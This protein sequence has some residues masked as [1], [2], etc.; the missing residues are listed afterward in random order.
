MGENN[1][2]ELSPHLGHE[3]I[4]KGIHRVGGFWP[5]GG[6]PRMMRGLWQGRPQASLTDPSHLHSRLGGADGGA[7]WTKGCPGA[8]QGLCLWSAHHCPA[9]G[10]K[11]LCRPLG[12]LQGAAQAPPALRRTPQP[13]SSPLSLS[14]SRGT[15]APRTKSSSGQPG[16]TR[17]G[18]PCLGMHLLH[19]H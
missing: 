19:L 10:T 12:V 3:I 14:A 7:L 16:S 6:L 17:P 18:D 5:G 4:H 2:N 1:G 8:A 15:A 9:P 11:T 13:C